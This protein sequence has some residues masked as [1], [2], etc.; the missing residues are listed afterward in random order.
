MLVQPGPSSRS[1]THIPE[2]DD[3]SGIMVHLTLERMILFQT[4]AP[5]MYIT[6]M[7]VYYSSTSFLPTNSL[8]A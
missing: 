3:Y 7:R 8:V 5:K 1:Q 6:T 4:Y 2:Y